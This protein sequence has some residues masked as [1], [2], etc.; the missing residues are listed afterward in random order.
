MSQGEILDF[1]IVL[2]FLREN[3]IVGFHDIGNQIT[4]SKH[5]NEWAPYIIFNMIRGKKYL[6]SGHKQLKHDIGIK[7]LD[8]NQKKYIHDYFRSLGGQWQYFPKENHITL[9]ME[10]LK[11]YY[12]NE[13]LLMF[14]ETVEFNRQFVKR[15]PMRVIY[16]YTKD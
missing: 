7:I 15:N 12:D 2:P 4:V 5:R 3:A 8:K 16:P 1:L 10:Y 6:P 11:K 9:I 13:C 14:N